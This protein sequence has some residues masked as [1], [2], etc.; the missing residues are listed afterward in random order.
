M[1]LVEVEKHRLTLFG[2]NKKVKDKLR[3]FLV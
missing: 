2:E 3:H 1:F